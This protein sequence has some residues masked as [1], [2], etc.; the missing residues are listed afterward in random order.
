MGLDAPAQILHLLAVG[1]LVKVSHELHLAAEH[2]LRDAVPQVEM[3]TKTG[4][5]Y[6]MEGSIM[7]WMTWR[8]IFVGRCMTWRAYL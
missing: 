5:Q 2:S 4:K 7:R 8:A 1:V 6:D 3:E